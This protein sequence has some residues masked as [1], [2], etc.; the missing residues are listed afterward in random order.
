MGT[1]LDLPHEREVFYE[2]ASQV[3]EMQFG[4]YV[5]VSATQSP[6]TG[7]DE[8]QRLLGEWTGAPFCS[9]TDHQFEDPMQLLS[10]TPPRDVRAVR[11]SSCS[12]TT[13]TPDDPDLRLSPKR[14]P[15]IRASV[16]LY[17]P[18]ED[19]PPSP[20]YDVKL[21]PISRALFEIRG[22]GQEKMKSIAK[23]KDREVN[24]LMQR[25]KYYGPTESSRHMRWQEEQ[26]KAKQLTGA[27]SGHV[28]PRSASQ[29]ANV[30]RGY[31]RHREHELLDTKSFVQTTELLRQ[32]KLE[33]MAKKAL[34]AAGSKSSSFSRSAHSTG[35]S[36]HGTRLLVNPHVVRDGAQLQK[37]TKK[38]G[39]TKLSSVPEEER[40]ACDAWIHDMHSCS[41]VS[42]SKTITDTQMQ[43]QPELSV[44]TGAP[45]MMAPE[46]MDLISPGADHDAAL[47]TPV[48][49]AHLQSP[50]PPVMMSPP[51]F[52]LSKRRASSF[53]CV[54]SPTTFDF[55]FG[56]DADAATWNVK[57]TVGA[58]DGTGAVADNEATSGS[59]CH[60]EEPLDEADPES[61]VVTSTSTKKA[62]DEAFDCSDIDDMLDY[63]DGV[64]LPI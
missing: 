16:W 22:A 36:G 4:A 32:R 5:E 46:A 11:A 43:T 13:F 52:S 8:V 38:H 6:F 17:D 7:V 24:K 28:R 51:R 23:Y 3:A 18:T 9:S 39:T 34:L 35:G 62:V 10:Q 45:V 19:H 58:G 15:C 53:S 40:G 33:L 37:R 26:K 12:S 55:E 44:D 14:K 59:A 47:S 29:G 1:K 63:F 31:D 57:T 49:I 60:S 56:H 27:S 30:G 20:E 64:S 50:I 25:S 2:E 54:P 42:S 21:R 48:P 41:I 61:E